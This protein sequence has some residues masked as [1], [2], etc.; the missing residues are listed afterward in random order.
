MKK[1]RFTINVLILCTAAI[2]G[3]SMVYEAG[4]EA[5][6]VTVEVTAAVV[7]LTIFAAEVFGN[8]K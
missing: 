3:G 5:V 1:N 8:K 4:S 2:I 7:F 6:G